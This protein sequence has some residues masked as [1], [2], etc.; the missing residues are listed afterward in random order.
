MDFTFVLTWSLTG[1]FFFCI[2]PF[3]TVFEV[4]ERFRWNEL[5]YKAAPFAG[6]E[7]REQGSWAR[8]VQGLVKFLRGRDGT[9]V[10]RIN[11]AT[12]LSP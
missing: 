1:N 3:S 9:W 11:W 8:I 4:H 2:E 7:S 12:L 5:G 10:C 6:Q